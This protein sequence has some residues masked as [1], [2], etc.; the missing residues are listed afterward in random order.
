MMKFIAIL[1][2]VA[3]L[4]AFSATA[5][6]FPG[7]YLDASVYDA[8]ISRYEAAPEG[9]KPFDKFSYWKLKYA[10]AILNREFSTFEA[11]LEAG[12]Q[13]I[14]SEYSDYRVRC[15]YMAM[16]ATFSRKTKSAVLVAL[17]KDAFAW[18]SARNYWQVGLMASNAQVCGILELS[19]DEIVNA[20]IKGLHNGDNVGVFYVER[21]LDALYPRLPKSSMPDA[22]Q[23]AALKKINRLYSAKL[24][25]PDKDK[26]EPIISKL[27]TVILSY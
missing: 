1:M 6:K 23:L 8:D 9:G 11:M 14:P 27:R 17:Y 3:A 13:A 16:H 18:L 26:W 7:W 12:S 15:A 10:R 22:D 24:I 19:N 20:L 5:Y 2:T 4:A 25:G 21:M